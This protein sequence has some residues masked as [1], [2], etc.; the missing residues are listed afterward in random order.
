MPQVATPEGWRLGAREATAN[1]AYFQLQ[2]NRDTEASARAGQW[3]R[4]GATR[5]GAAGARFAAS[6]G[7][8][9]PPVPRKFLR[10]EPM[11]NPIVQN[12]FIET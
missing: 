9:A 7:V 4:A 12:S 11:P 1:S 3:G 6:W 8:F 5:G 10:G 2:S